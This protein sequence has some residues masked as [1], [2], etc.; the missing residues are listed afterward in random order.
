MVYT[1]YHLPQHPPT[2]IALVIFGAL[3]LQPSAGMWRYGSLEPAAAWKDGWRRTQLMEKD[4]IKKGIANSRRL[5]NLLHSILL[6]KP[7]EC[8]VKMRGS[9]NHSLYTGW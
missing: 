3:E 4:R 9:L 7:G 1:V 2:N 8:G 5:L 6:L